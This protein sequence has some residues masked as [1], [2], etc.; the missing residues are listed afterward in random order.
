MM[1]RIL[2]ALIAMLMLAGCAF[3][4]EEIYPECEFEIDAYGGALNLTYSDG[5]T[6][7]TGGWGIYAEIT[8]EGMTIGDVLADLDVSGIEAS[9]E[10]EVFEG[11]LVFDVS[12][13]T[14]EY[15]FDENSYTLASDAPISTEE[16]L[17]LPA[18]EEHAMYAAKWA[19][20]PAE[21]YFSYE[22][23]YME[24]ETI[25]MASATL[26]ANGGSFLAHG[27]EEDYEYALSVASIEP[28]QLLGEA[29]EL[30]NL[31]RI[32]CE[33]RDF[34]GWTIYEVGSMEITEER[35]EEDGLPCFELG[36]DWYC[37]L[38]DASIISED[39][40]TLALG[41]FVC[42]ESDLFVIATWE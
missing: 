11:W 10:G 24:V 27:E 31:L 39:M 23:E 22:E 35:T 8:K 7:E 21:E 18:P 41:E 20:I 42:G 1:K 29:L 32:S 38:H 5:S 40:D 17:A 34:S 28:G 4:E 13:T 9:L 19:G 37:T 15:G 12:T 33:G 26:F 6:E 30:E 16:L 14:D 3:G 2:A 25:H 36:E